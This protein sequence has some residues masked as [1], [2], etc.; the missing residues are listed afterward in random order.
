MIEKDYLIVGQGIAGTLLSYFLL[1]R[2]KD[3]LVIDNRFFSSAS[4]VAA[5]LFN[6]ITGRKNVKSWNADI[7]FPFAEDTYRKIEKYLQADLY[8][9]LEMHKIFSSAGE[10]SDWISKKDSAE[11]HEFIRLLNPPLKETIH[12][13]LYGGIE[14]LKAGYVDIPL[15]LSAF[16]TKMQEE[17][18]LLEGKVD[19]SDLFV[20]ENKVV[21][22]GNQFK[23]VLFCDG[24]QAT[25]NPFFTW[26]P[27]V[28]AKGEVITFY[29][30]QLQLS[31]IVNKGIFILPLGEDKYKTG[32]TYE[33]NFAHSNPTG[34]GKK[35][36]T[37]RLD[38]VINCE[39]EIIDHQAG[40]RPASKDRMPFIGIHPNH[41]NFGVFNGLGTKG[42]TLAPFF[43]NHFVEFL[44]EGKPLQ[45]EIDIL[46][47]SSLVQ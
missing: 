34:E 20:H 38:Q 19:Y 25:L 11:L 14:I 10:E 37:D 8:H 21:W 35:S 28:P 17:K 9:P 45:K 46:R 39:Y 36:L 31:K 23:K 43:A 13:S 44:E 5:G 15:L 4:M 29:S 41:S 2:N 26:L 16:K 3:I 18:R 40:I 7:L 42:I 32:S 27:F 47:Y 1:K 22:K 6:P 12:P 24:F 30:K 33:W